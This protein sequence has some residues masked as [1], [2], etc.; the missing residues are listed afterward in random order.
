MTTRRRLRLP[1]RRRALPARA[2][3]ARRRRAA[4]RHARRQSRA[5]RIWFE[6]VA[7][8]AARLRHPGD[9]AGRPERAGRRRAR[10]RA[11]ARLPLLASTTARCWSAPLLAIAARGALNMHGSLLPQ[12]PRPRAGELGGAPRRD[13]RPARRCT[14]WPRSPTPATSSRSRRCRSC[15]TT[16]R[17]RCST[18]SRVAAEIA[19]DRALPALLAGTAPRVPQDLAHGRYFGGRKPEDGR[20]DW[21]QRR[22]RDPQP[23]ARRRA[24]LSRA[25]SRTIGGHAGCASCARACSTGRGR[26]A[27]RRRSYADDGACI[28]RLRRR[29]HA[30]RCSTLELDGA[31]VDR[32]RTFAR[33]ASARPTSRVAT[34][35][36]A[37]HAELAMKK[38]LILGVNGFIGH[39]LSKRI[40]ATTDWEVYGMDMQTDRITDL[41]GRA[42]LPLLRRRHH[43]QQGVDRV[44]RQEVRRD[45]A[46]GGDRHAG[47]LRASEPLRVFELD[48]EANLPIVR[49]CVQLQQAHRVPVDLRG[50]RHVPRRRVR[51]GELRTGAAARSTSRAGS[52]PAPSS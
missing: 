43:D 52:T 31:A 22:R 38:V 45:P 25:R 8:V 5:R 29:R 15:P 37:D 2:A 48:F 50:L 23:G 3:R 33:D 32:R 20:I 4:G 21:S 13:A 6:R 44:P 27:R 24:A 51:P 9:H 17:A 46:A 49:A 14:T 41:L 1:Q 42:A 40:L 26:G 39:H 47:H 35:I 7:D 28:A 19:L 16:P 36:A 34:G 18:R 10:S 12:V 30:A 11:R